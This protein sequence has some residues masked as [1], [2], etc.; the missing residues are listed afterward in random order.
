MYI[1]LVQELSMTEAK[2]LYVLTYLDNKADSDF[3][4]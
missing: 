4:I 3:D 2:S 1:V